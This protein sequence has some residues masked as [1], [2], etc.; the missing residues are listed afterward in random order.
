VDV[1]GRIFCFR[2]LITQ[3]KYVLYSG[4]IRNNLTYQ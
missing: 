2:E 4:K 3:E 1:V